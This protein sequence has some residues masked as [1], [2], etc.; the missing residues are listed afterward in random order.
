MSLTGQFS[1]Q[2]LRKLPWSKTLPGRPGAPRSRLSTCPALTVR[3]LGLHPRPRQR[4]PAR[5][6]AAAEQRAAAPTELLPGERAT[7][8]WLTSHRSLHCLCASGSAHLLSEALILFF[9]GTLRQVEVGV[10]GCSR[11]WSIPSASRVLHCVERLQQSCE[12]YLSGMRAD[13]RR[14][15]VLGIRGEKLTCEGIYYRT[16]THCAASVVA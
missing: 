9:Q 2:K 4:C 1:T 5:W 15:V 14:A 6:T 8:R 10:L 16:H 3:G 7:L 12:N 13:S 11:H